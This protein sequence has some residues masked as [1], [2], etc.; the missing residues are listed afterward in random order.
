MDSSMTNVSQIRCDAILV[1]RDRAP[2]LHLPH[3]YLEDIRKKA[4]SN[5]L[6]SSDVLA[7]LWAT[8]ACPVLTALGFVQPPSTYK[9]LPRMWWVPTGPLSRFALHAAYYHGKRSYETVSIG[10]GIFATRCPSRTSISKRQDVLWNLPDC[11]VF[12]FAGHAHADDQNP[13]NSQLRLHDWKDNPLRMP[14]LLD[15]NL[16]AHAPFL[17]YLSACETGR[18]RNDLFLD[19][20]THLINAVQLAGFRHVIGTWPQDM[21]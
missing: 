9:N 8:I 13:P 16:N 14:D 20:C 12:H 6:G 7:W 21:L 3:L 5:D 1:E 2:S 17:A 11:R 10:Q 18:I 4:E 19:E 15:L